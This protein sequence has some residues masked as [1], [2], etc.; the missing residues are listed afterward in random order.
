MSALNEWLNKSVLVVTNDGR[1]IVG[2]LKGYDNM[3]NIVLD[4]SFE[5]I[6]SADQD[7]ESSELGLHVIR[8]DNIAI[9]GAHDAEKEAASGDFT[10]HR[11]A[12]IKPVVH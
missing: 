9:I 7:V 4:K 12:P 6:Y 10:K 3:T 5:R 1:T 2:V 8:G 11:C